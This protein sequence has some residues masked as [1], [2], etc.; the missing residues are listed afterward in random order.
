MHSS[1]R[2][3]E[4]ICELEGYRW[5]AVLLTADL[6]ALP[7]LTNLEDTSQTRIHGSRKIRQQTRSWNYAE[8]EGGD[9][10]SSI[11]S[12]SAN[13][14]SQERFW[15]TINA[16]SWWAYTFTT[17]GYA[18]HHVEKMYR[19]IEKHTN[20][21][22]KCIQIVGGDLN[23]ELVPGCGVERTWVLVRTL[24]MKKKKKRRLGWSTGRCLK[25]SQHSTRYAEWRLENKRLTDLPKEP[26]SKSTTI[27]IKRRHLKYNKDAE[28]ND[29]MH[30]GSDHRCVM[31]TFVKKKW[32]TRFFFYQKTKQRQARNNKA[33]QPK[34]NGQQSRRRRIYVRQQDTKRS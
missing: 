19:T 20:F 25:I 18:D 30:M 14:P 23:A 22:K 26:R 24:S 27:L 15:S 6:E 21:S 8:Q 12:T 13:G 7:S 28:A 11:M 17:F 16:S 10:K 29:L 34:T 4:M 3:E 2:I 33:E 5:D 1:E 31:A 9:K 32:P